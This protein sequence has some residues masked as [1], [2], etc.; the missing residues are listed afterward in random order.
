MSKATAIIG[1]LLSFICGASFLWALDRSSGAHPS[2]ATADTA[3][4]DGMRPAK[5]GAVRVDLHVMSQCP[6]GVQAEAA[7]KDVVAKFGA[8]LDLHVEFIGQTTPTGELSSMHGAN[9][10]KGDMLQACAIKHAP[11]K[12]FDFIL[13]QNAN[14]K[15]VA[16]NAAAC[17]TQVGAP[18]D[19]IVACAAGQ[20]GK[21]L[22]AASFKASTEKGAR[23]SPTIFI[24]GAK[25]EGGRKPTDL[26]KAI[27]SAG[28]DKKPAGCSDIPEAP[29]V[30]VTILS[31]ARCGADCDSKR[32]EGQLRSK[33]GNPVLRTVDY[34]SPEGKKLYE[35]FKPSNLP[36]LVFDKT[37]DA[38]KDAQQAFARNAKEVAGGKVVPMGG[39]NPACAD[40]GG[41]KLEEC[42]ATMQC[43]EE[44]PK[45][46]DVF[47]MSQC[48][49]GVKGLDAMKEV[50]DNF[51][52]AGEKVDFHIHFIGDGDAKALK[53]MHGQGEV[54]E[55]IRE[56]CAIK[57]Y[58][59]DLKYMDYIWCRNKSIKDSNWQACTGGSTGIDT[60]RMQKCFE[61]DEGKDLIARSFADSKAAGMSASPTWL[62]NNKFKFSGVDP[63]TI[64]TNLCAH[65]KLPGC[66][67]K[68]TG[69]AAPAG[70]AQP[71]GCGG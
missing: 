41:C 70:A 32:I 44:L 26:M 5:P 12:W 11:T 28:G 46:L 34:A 66:E 56:A 4:S 60:A 10:V 16:T 54:D 68:L 40:D 61:G 37:L 67:N 59:K 55:D 45:R 3:R 24:N 38:D 15:E 29:K 49:F 18:A 14:M 52:K 22:L 9:E 35:S 50:V 42:K 21:D 8:D 1:F 58:P 71:A 62:V 36:A 19:K 2:Q 43:R 17:A 13:C 64:K 23:G 31:D 57:H 6:Y 65:N 63:E 30:N 39:W 20:E 27:C 47:V 69:R 53:S 51:A 33:V 25:Y 48:P 7:F